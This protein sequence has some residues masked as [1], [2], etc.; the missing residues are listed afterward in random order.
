M[1]PSP[2]KKKSRKR[3]WLIIA[4]VVFVL[5]LASAI[6]LR[7][8]NNSTTNSP[9]TTAAPTQVPTHAVQSTSQITP[10]V[11]STA[12]AKN[13]K[14]VKPTHGI[15]TIEGQ[16]SDFFGKYG[17]PLT[18]NGKDT[19]WL[20]SSDGS[21]SLDVRDT[22]RGVVGYMSVST[23]DSWSK[24]KLQAFCLGFAPH[25]YT[26]DRTSIPSN[27][28]IVYVYNS[29]RGKF[30]LHLSPGYPEYCYMNTLP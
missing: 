15:P 14:Y 26:L 12:T 10:V 4:A 17:T 2:P 9:Q 22:G 21:L 11:T 19:V 27:S 16:I 8:T 5:A 20:L 1:Q 28:S 30:A 23:P 3:L 7:S 18:T 13:L 6:A 29:P 25:D 24:Q